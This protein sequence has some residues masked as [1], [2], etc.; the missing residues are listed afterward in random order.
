[1]EAS[2]QLA[3]ALQEDGIQHVVCTPHVFPGRHDNTSTSIAAHVSAMTEALREAGIPLTLSWAGEVRL[4]PEVLG[5]LARNELPFLGVSPAGQRFMLLEMPDG[6]IP[7]GTDRFVA[8]LLQARVTPILAHPERNRA[9]MED[10]RRIGPLVAMGCGL[11]LTASSLTGEFG[12]R[13][14]AVAQRLLDKSWVQA[15]ASDAHNLGGRRPR[16]SAA[17]DWLSQHYGQT[18]AMRLTLLG[19]ASLSRQ[20]EAK[21]PEA[22]PADSR[23]AAAAP[24]LDEEPMLDGR[25]LVAA[26][27][28]DV[29]VAFERTAAAQPDKALP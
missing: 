18:A 21:L 11:Q 13:V 28:V 26:D 19:P 17:S 12:P 27:R 25:V 1:M 23:T 14:Q 5:L 10:Y 29:P 22:G 9:V 2:L 8:K 16:M 4:M 3:R 20:P 24:L 6:Q 7:V 15:V